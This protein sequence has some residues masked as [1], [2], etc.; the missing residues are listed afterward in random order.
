[1][2]HIQLKKPP[3]KRVEPPETSR[4]A[5][6]TIEDLQ[7]PNTGRTHIKRTDYWHSPESFRP[8]EAPL[9]PQS[10]PHL[11]AIVSALRLEP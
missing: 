9:Y 11:V 5:L 6:D 4:P 3:G 10:H 2:P 8:R 7:Q 1:M